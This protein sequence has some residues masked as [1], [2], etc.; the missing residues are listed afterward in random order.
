M[1]HYILVDAG[2]YSARLIQADVKRPPL[3]DDFLHQHNLLV[4]IRGQRLIEAE[5]YSSVSCGITAATVNELALIDTSSNQFRNVLL[6]YPNLLRPTFTEASVRHGVQHFVT[7]TGQPVY[8][9]AHRLSPG[10][11]T[12]AKHEFDEM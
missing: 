1:C 6:E 5:T 11:L 7:T 12:I 2:R 8:A 9:N 10:K 3:G 4:D